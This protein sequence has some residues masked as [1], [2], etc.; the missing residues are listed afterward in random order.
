VGTESGTSLTRL[1]EEL[2]KHGPEFNVF[3]A[4]Y[5]A[6][7]A[8]KKYHP[9]R[10]DEH[11]EQ[12]GLKFRPYEKYTFPPTDI[13]G[14]QFENHTMKFVLNF[15]GLYGI[16]SPLPRCYHEQ[17]AEQQ[18]IHG[19]GEVPLQNFLEIFNN[20]FYWHYY[21]AWK[22][23][24]H[25]LALNSPDQNRHSDRILSFIGLGLQSQKDKSVPVSKFRLM[26]ISSIL[27]CR[28]KNKAGLRI[29][30]SEFFPKYAI[31]IKEFVPRMVK[32]N[33]VPSMGK[34]S[35]EPMRL[36]RNSVLGRSILDYQSKITIEIGPMDFE[37][38]LKFLP[39]GYRATLLKEV[40]DLYINEGI[41]YDVEFLIK[42][43]KIDNVPWKNDQIRLGQSVWLGKPKGNVVKRHYSFEKFMTVR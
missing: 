8:S 30:L 28:V 26:R 19:E 17:V 25:Y 2:E 29:A 32:L 42:T 22:K 37:D 34:N 18:D 6:E 39:D 35:E 14:F 4:F 12:T 11:F 23:Y 20:R 9:R 15:M 10:N 1:I 31:K 36:G 3:Q 40:I 43:E 5:L 21:Q 16:N 33:R 24:R 41:E 13:R 7:R 27:S 38:Y